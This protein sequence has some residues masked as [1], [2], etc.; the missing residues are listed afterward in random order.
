MSLPT[1]T[2][3][4]LFTDIEGSTRLMQELG[5]RYV[6]AQVAHH[7]ILRD[8][9][10]SN[11]GRELRTEGD[12]F[13]CVFKSAL[14]ACGAAAKAQRDLSR[15]TWPDGKAIRVRIGLH[16]GEAPLVGEEYIGID[17]HHAARVAA[18]AH[19][20]QVVVSDATRSLVES[21]LPSDLGLRDLGLHRLKDLA[22]PERL[23]QLVIAGAP[24]TFP[25]LRTIDSTPNNLPTQLTSFVGREDMVAE[26]ERILK[27]TRLLTLTGPGGIGKTR[28]SLQIAADAVQ[29]F[30]DGVYFVP[31]SAVSDPTLVASVIAQVIGIPVAG[32]RL[33]FDAVVDYLGGKRVLLV[34]DNLEQ[35]LPKGAPVVSDLLRAIPDLKCVVSSRAVLHVYG[36]HELAVAPLRTPDLKT[37]PSLAALSQFDAVKLFIERAVAAR[38]DFE[39]TN[40]NAPAIAGICERLDGLP[41]AIELA[42]ARVKLFSPQALL[43]RLGTGVSVLGTGSRDVPGRQ[44]TL[45]GA[46]A[47]SY[48]LLDEPLKRLFRRFSVFARGASLEQAEAVC[49]PASELG[50]DV[51]TGLDELADQSLLRALPDFD[52]PRLLMLQV[53]REYAGERL[54]GSGEADE[55]KSRHAAAYQALAEAAAG[56]LFGSQQKKWL[57]R[58]ELDHDNFR[59]AFDWSV[60]HG[61]A[62]RAL[63]LG[64]AFWRFWQMRG[65]LREGRARLDAILGLP[66]TGDHPADRARALEAAGGVAYWQGEM[67]AAQVYYDEALELT[68]PAGDERALANALYNASFPRNVGR[69]DLPR[70]RDLLDEALS[71]YRRLDDE[72]GIA[73]CLWALGQIH[74]KLEDFPEAIVAIDEAIKLF[75]QQGDRFGLGW[76][77]F[78]RGSIYLRMNDVEAARLRER[79]ALEI[80]A[81]AEDVSGAVLVLTSLAEV[82]RREGDAL[83]AARLAGAAAGQEASSGTGLGSLVG[84]VEGWQVRE[85]LS[86]EEQSALAEGKAMTLEQAVAYALEEDRVVEKGA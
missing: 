84:L 17:V 47:W 26:S 37:L 58:L 60:A 41:L 52:E 44:Q 4:F 14:D 8:A 62:D 67:D 49:G 21:S 42:A 2:V 15:S 29:Q 38:H 3:T 74:Y 36:E 40:D 46:I 75:R 55:I 86:Q 18:S 5:E 34:L 33:P 45:E 76:A 39:V 30:P 6:E 73:R 80:F 50:V 20:G 78:V 24:S 72:H 10:K 9:F 70:A 32:N 1:G 7:E 69:T 48:D 81:A 59:V 25:P 77:V 51:L 11:D 66:G 13:F 23:F 53:I 71:I 68:R 19:G 63:C 27:Q 85:D 12:S 82:A 16:T 31:L 65:H 61:V 35:L 79:E 54:T 43:T 22:R 56:N 64:A 57:D 83:R 28:L